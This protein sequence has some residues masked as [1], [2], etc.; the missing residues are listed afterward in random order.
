MSLPIYIC[1][2]VPIYAG[3]IPTY[4]QYI[5]YISLVGIYVHSEWRAQ[6]RCLDA[7]HFYTVNVCLICDSL[8]LCFCFPLQVATQLTTKQSPVYLC[9]KYL[10]CL[11]D[12]HCAAWGYVKRLSHELFN[13]IPAAVFRSGGVRGGRRGGSSGRGGGRSSGRGPGDPSS[14]TGGASAAMGAADVRRED[15]S[16]QCTF[17]SNGDDFFHQHW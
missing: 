15:G 4:N 2:R 16:V 7:K 17:S 3:I 6:H 1:R 10:Q 9:I 11:N 12:W 14:A 13:M 8:V 5:S